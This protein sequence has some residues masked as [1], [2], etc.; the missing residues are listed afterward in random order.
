M[1]DI[2]PKDLAPGT[3]NPSG[4]K[5]IV[6]LNFVIP[7]GGGVGVGRLRTLLGPSQPTRASCLSLTQD[8]SK[9]RGIF[10]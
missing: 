10:V 3:R 5:V 8:R 4:G 7:V 9:L 6:V 1:K 2:S